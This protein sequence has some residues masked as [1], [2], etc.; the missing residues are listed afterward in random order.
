M[1]VAHYDNTKIKINDESN[2]TT[3]NKGNYLIIE[4]N[5]FINGNM[6]LTSS[7]DVFVYQGIGGNSEANQGMFFVPPLSCESRGDVNNIAF[8]DE[9]GDN[10]FDGGVTIVTKKRYCKD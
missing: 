10:T 5:K 3:I 8:I 4:G 1:V 9:I 2:E 6:Y 7:E